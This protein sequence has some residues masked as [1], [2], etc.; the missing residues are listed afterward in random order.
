M[1][2]AAQGYSSKFLTCR[3]DSSEGRNNLKLHLEEV[4][5][6]GS[7]L[8]N[9]IQRISKAANRSF[10]FIQTKIQKLAGLGEVTPRLGSGH[11]PGDAS[12]QK[13]NNSSPVDDGPST[14][15]AS[16]GNLTTG[17][18]RVSTSNSNSITAIT[19][20]PKK[21][22][23]FFLKNFGGSAQEA[24]WNE[25]FSKFTTCCDLNNVPQT[26]RVAVLGFYLRGIPKGCYLD[27]F[28]KNQEGNIK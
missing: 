12:P 23:K 24:P 15:L 5:A 27:I 22:L 18:E 26:K 3:G 6:T 14:L 17:T 2:S 8:E 21:R 25:F 10:E 1:L 19:T 20:K 7:R 28:N 4:L 13:L 9:M 16:E 11:I